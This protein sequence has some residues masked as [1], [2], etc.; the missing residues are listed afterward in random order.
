MKSKTELFV[1]SVRTV[2]IDGYSVIPSVIRYL[3]ADSFLIGHDARDGDELSD[4]VIDDF[5]IGLGAGDYAMLQRRAVTI[6][7]NAKRSVVGI[8][9]DFITRAL[10]SVRLWIVERGISSPQHILVAEPLALEDTSTPGESWLSHYRSNM[11]RIL[12]SYTNVDFLPEPFAVFQYYRYGIRH[13]LIAAKRK[14]IALVLDFGGGTFDVSVVET[15]AQGDISQSGRNQRPLAS[16]SVAVA[17]YYINRCIAERLLFKAAPELARNRVA[18]RALELYMKGNWNEGDP[19]INLEVHTLLRNFQRLVQ[20]AEKAKIAICSSII[21]WDLN[22]NLSSKVPVRVR[23][24]ATPFSESTD[25]VEISFDAAEL[26][27][28]FE[29]EVWNRRLR[30]TISEVLKRASSEL[31]GNPV[32]VVLLSGGSSNIGWLKSLLQRDLRSELPSAEVV[33]L[34]ENFQEIVSKGLAIEC[35]RRYYTDGEGDFKAVL[36]NRLC[37]LLS[38]NGKGTELRKYRVVGP[39]GLSESGEAGVLLPSASSLGARFDQELRWK[40]KLSS[41]PTRSLEYYFMRASFDPNDLEGQLNVVQKVVHTPKDVRFGS[42]IDVSLTVREDGTALPAFIYGHDTSVQG[43]PF[44]LDMT[45]AAGASNVESYIGFDFGSSTSSFSLVSRADVN[46]YRE[47]EQDQGWKEINELLPS[48]PY[49]VAAPLARYLGETN[50]G[51]IF[52]RGRSA[53]EASLCFASFLIYTEYRA[54]MGRQSSSLF[55]NLRNRSAGPLWALL[56]ESL[57]KLPSANKITSPLSRVLLEPYRTELGSAVDEIA[58]EKH[59]KLASVDFNRTLR[60]VC[61]FIAETVRDKVFGYFEE[62]RQKAFSCEYE[63]VFRSMRGASEPFVDLYAYTGAY[64]F[65]RNQVF[66]VDLATGSAVELTPVYV[67][68]LNNLAGDNR[69][70]DLFMFDS[71]KGT[72]FSYNAVQE[73]NSI[74]LDE[75]GGLGQLWKLVSDLRVGDRAIGRCTDIRLRQR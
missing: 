9:Q 52:K 74:A 8:A 29:K 1:N 61:N 49:P 63:G 14:H 45:S 13:P 31:E 25:F 23:V 40:V 47:R 28:T 37:L 72:E 18:R 16:K 39:V 53:L 35:A 50:A 69:P 34:A 4:V 66:L 7:E 33:E 2:T 17:G 58:E 44:F 11:R 60:P 46:V 70:A 75:S 56:R 32:S 65:S 36:Y 19:T 30:G 6:R 27:E 21:S 73:R 62:V 71:V 20:R 48:L 26:R 24:P 38:P 57:D 3:S 54:N 64:S 5:K 43:T 51:S 68:G 59:D 42:S 15:T 22:A 10:Q 41:A 55:R 67:W 12:H